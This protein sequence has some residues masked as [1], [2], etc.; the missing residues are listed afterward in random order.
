V[1]R[2]S[3]PALHASAPP[4]RA[5]TLTATWA[6]NAGTFEGLDRHAVELQWRSPSGRL[7]ILKQAVVNVLFEEG[8]SC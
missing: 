1:A 6:D 5:R 4:S 3:G 2:C 7:A 8:A